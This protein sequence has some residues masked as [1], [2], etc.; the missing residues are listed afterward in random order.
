M[1]NGPRQPD[2]SGLSIKRNLALLSAA[3][4]A[5]TCMLQLIS[6]VASISH[7]DYLRSAP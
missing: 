4:A 1:A 3:V 5:N 6:G 7:H 2:S